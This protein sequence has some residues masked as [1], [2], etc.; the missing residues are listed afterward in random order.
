MELSLFFLIPLFYL[1]SY[2]ILFWVFIDAKNKRGMN[3]GCLWALIV[4]ATG[5]LGLIAYLIVRNA[6]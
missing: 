2:L 5:P 3:I 4:L 6:D 1:A